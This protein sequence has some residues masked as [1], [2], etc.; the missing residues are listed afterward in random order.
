MWGQ[1]KIPDHFGESLLSESIDVRVELS[2]VTAAVDLHDVRSVQRCHHLKWVEGQE[3]DAAVR[4]DDLSK[5]TVNIF[6]SRQRVTKLR[7]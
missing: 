6:S 7:L 4:V 2:E 5:E 3:D 1:K